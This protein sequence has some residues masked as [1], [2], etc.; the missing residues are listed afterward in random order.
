MSAKIKLS[1][2]LKGSN[3]EPFNGQVFYIENNMR[4]WMSSVDCLE[5][6]GFKY[7]DD[8][9]WVNS[10]ELSLYLP[11]SDMP[12]P[13]LDKNFRINKLLPVI[14]IRQSTGLEIGALANPIVAKEVGNVYY[15]DYATK[16][17]LIKN[18]TNDLHDNNSNVIGWYPKIDISRIVDVDFI[19][20]QQTLRE[21]IP[22]H[23]EFDYVI[24]SHV[25]E[26]VPDIIGWLNEIADVLKVGGIVSL[27]I[28]DKRH[29]FDYFRETTT[30]SEIIDAFL[31]QYRRPTARQI[32][33][34]YSNIAQVS[35][36]DTWDKV[37]TKNDV[38]LFYSDDIALKYCL[39]SMET[40]Q[41]IDCH[42]SVFTCDTF[43]E[44]LEKLF[45]LDLLN[46]KVNFLY[47]PKFYM[48]EFIVVLEKL[49]I[50]DKMQKLHIQL[51]SIC[52]YK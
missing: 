2:V 11:T 26:H 16:D 45:K 21:S 32:F 39:D 6:Y 9:E 44:I 12:L 41:Y 29:T 19:W 46:F 15:V 20:G 34:H 3:E 42:C 49:P 22:Q 38:S 35:V 24:A 51:N 36:T 37:L 28:P 27:A 30:V 1:G 25:I 8:V 4:H 47:K 7:P 10:E 50:V 33:D 48:N 18:F 31:N 13:W 17:Q 5:A 14:K 43:I 52:Q 23:L 40:E